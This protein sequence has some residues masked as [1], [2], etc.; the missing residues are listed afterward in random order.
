MP[1]QNSE[2]ALEHRDVDELAAAGDLPRAARS[3]MPNAAYMPAVMSAIDTPQRTPRP[4]GSPV[5][6]IMPLSAC[7]TR[8]NAARLRYG[9]SWPKPEIEQ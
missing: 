1:E 2:L 6:L 7:T 9:P 5:T 8:S 3:R 4:P